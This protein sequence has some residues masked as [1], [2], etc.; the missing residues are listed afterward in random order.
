MCS[1]AG[2]SRIARK[3]VAEVEAGRA[4]ALIPFRY[5]PEDGVA[6]GVCYGGSHP[7]TALSADGHLWFATNH[8]V[9]E[10]RPER[11]APPLPGVGPRLDRVMVDGRGAEPVRR[12]PLE[13]PASA[14][15]VDFSFSAPVFVSQQ[16][17]RFRYRL[18]GFDRDW[19]VDDRAGVARYTSLDPGSYH[20]EVALRDQLGEWGAP[21]ALAAIEVEPPLYQ[22]PGFVAVAALALLAAAAGARGP[23]RP[24][25]GGAA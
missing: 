5:G 12:N 21:V 24:E 3:A 25:D 13:V 20:F 23:G 11:L 16:R 22:R 2:I 4:A 17:T 19:V 7:A 10:I 18:V 6:E 9:V 14:R 15:R 1:G 8:G